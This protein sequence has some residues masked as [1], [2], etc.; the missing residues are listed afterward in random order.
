MTE[1]LEE[2]L[3]KEVTAILTRIRTLSRS[4]LEQK[5]PDE[6]TKKAYTASISQL[7]AQAAKIKTLYD[8]IFS[9]PQG[10]FSSQFGNKTWVKKSLPNLTQDYV[11]IEKS[12]I[13][14]DCYTTDDD[15]PKHPCF[16]CIPNEGG[17]LDWV[18][19]QNTVSYS[20]SAAA[21]IVESIRKK[22]EAHA[23]RIGADLVIY[24]CVKS[25]PYSFRIKRVSGLGKYDF[26]GKV[27]VKFYKLKAKNG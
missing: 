2:Q 1:T 15:P 26:Q 21:F 22:V 17:K 11:L 3:G 18:I 19:A 24:D 16:T 6:A 7:A 23:N 12:R 4:N 20:G 14:S 27:N 9:F 5:L 10:T 13:A 8:S 25:S